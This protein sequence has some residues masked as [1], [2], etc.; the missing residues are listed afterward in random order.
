MT[1]IR[2]WPRHLLDDEEETMNPADGAALDAVITRRSPW[3]GALIGVGVAIAAGLL[4][5]LA[6]SPAHADDAPV[7]PGIPVDVGAAVASVV[8]PPPTVREL[9]L[10]GATAGVIADS[11]PAQTVTQPVAETLDGLLGVGEPTAPVAGVV[12][13]TLA[14]V[15]GVTVP[16]VPPVPVLVPEPA[17]A[18][19]APVPAAASTGALASAAVLLAR[20]AAPAVVALDVLTASADASPLGLLPGGTPAD[21]PPS[22]LAGAG[23]APGLLAI[24]VL[25]AALLLLAAGRPRPD[26][27]RAP[28][29]PTLDIDT[30][31]A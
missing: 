20:T 2:G 5:L 10:V 16:E 1:P 6:P 8:A 3:R 13:D 28:R 22:A 17:S 15:V 31:P 7:L 27:F 14:T 4:V 21:P 23:G 12:D 18:E 29:P 25:G 24:A 26:A 19:P 9:P 11:S 30:S